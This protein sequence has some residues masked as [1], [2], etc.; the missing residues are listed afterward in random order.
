LP[1]IRQ[2]KI[3]VVAHRGASAY[4]CEN[5]IEAIEEAVT[6]KADMVE[7][8]LR[9]TSDNKIILFHYPFIL[10]SNGKKI[11]ISR[12]CFT[13]LQNSAR[14]TGH[15]LAS[16]DEVLYLFKDRIR[17]NIEIKMSGFEE[18]VLAMLRK[19][20]I[21]NDPVISSFKKEVINNIRQLDK[22]I[23]LGYI[24]GRSPANLLDI[25]NKPSLMSYLDKN[26][27]TSVHLHKDIAGESIIKKLTV[28]GVS[29]Y[30][31]TVD[32]KDDYLKFIDYGVTGI[33]TDT[34]DKL[35]EM[36]DKQ[37]AAF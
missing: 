10:A 4:K 12:T 22:N 2:N 14:E 31:W 33:I 29:V 3:M 35:R 5:T 24:L 13:D 30:I 8:D 17:F 37:I 21:D 6:Q 36:V 9:Q 32:N 27:I 23:R 7:F 25:I 18:T 16:F 15:D 26:I 28:E 20:N 11:I 1:N 34:P 19:Y